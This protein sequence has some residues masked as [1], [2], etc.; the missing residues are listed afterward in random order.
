MVV[1]LT[2]YFYSKL[3]DSK[4]YSGTATIVSSPSF[5]KAIAVIEDSEGNDKGQ[6]DIYSNVFWVND[7]LK[8]KYTKKGRKINIKE[9][10]ATVDTKDEKAK[11]VSHIGSDVTMR[12]YRENLETIINL[13]QFEDVDDLNIEIDPFVA[14]PERISG[15]Y[16]NI[17]ITPTE[18]LKMMFRKVDL[19]YDI[20]K[21][22]T[23]LIKSEL[24]FKILSLDYIT[25]DEIKT[26]L[27]YEY[28]NKSFTFKAL[29]GEGIYSAR[30][31]F[32][33]GD[34]IKYIFA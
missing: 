15:Q 9:I 26:N 3:N 29:G 10:E 33:N 19:A 5:K 27:I 32:E 17:E 24:N 7:K 12:K 31:E 18:F 30:L 14:L 25:K 34:I 8:V 22:S 4:L 2:I 21:D 23:V 1:G 13:N 6:A 28:G 16:Y 11:I 20:V